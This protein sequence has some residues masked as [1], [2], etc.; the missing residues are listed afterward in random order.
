M[1]LVSGRSVFNR[2]T[3]SSFC[4]IKKSS[5]VIGVT[6]K[7]QKWP[8]GKGQKPNTSGRTIKKNYS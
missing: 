6:I 3:R 8:I 5:K 2:A 4:W 7:D 1:E